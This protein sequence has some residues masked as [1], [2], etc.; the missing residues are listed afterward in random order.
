MKNNGLIY[1][2]YSYHFWAKNLCARE[3]FY[4]LSHFILVTT[5][6]RLFYWY[7]YFIDKKIKVE[8]G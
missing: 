4:V 6:Q 8:K 3:G 7:P 1:I 2:K 5:L